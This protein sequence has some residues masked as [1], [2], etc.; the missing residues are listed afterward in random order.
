MF[1][2]VTMFYDFIQ[3]LINVLFDIEFDFAGVTVSY[4]AM[5]VT[6]MIFAFAV[7]VFWRGARA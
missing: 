3:E 5:I 2:F 6:G 1:S 4:G 7:F